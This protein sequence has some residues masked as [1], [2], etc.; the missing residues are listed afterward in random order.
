[1][2]LVAMETHH[3]QAGL[4]LI[5]SFIHVTWAVLLRAPGVCCEQDTEEHQSIRLQLLVS[6]VCLTVQTNRMCSAVTTTKSVHY[7]TC[8]CPLSCQ[9]VSP[10][11]GDSKTTETIFVLPLAD[12]LRGDVLW[13]GLGLHSQPIRFT[14]SKRMECVN[15]FKSNKRLVRSFRCIFQCVK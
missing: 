10:S 4:P 5:H 9:G 11:L 15:L 8:W 3:L 13:F 2:K 1:M 7:F 14:V 6:L 12:N